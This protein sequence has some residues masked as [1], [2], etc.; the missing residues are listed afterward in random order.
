MCFSLV[1]SDSG[2]KLGVDDFAAGWNVAATN[3]KDCGSASGNACANTLCEADEVFSEAVGPDVLV[4]PSY[5][6]AVFQGVTGHL[7]DDRVGGAWGV[8]GY[9]GDRWLGSVVGFRRYQ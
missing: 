3:K 7:F 8:F 6:V 4:R 9:K 2:H 5:E 1:G